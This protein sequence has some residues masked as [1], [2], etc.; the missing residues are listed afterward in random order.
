M[1]VI[2]SFATKP[3]TEGDDQADHW[4]SQMATL[5]LPDVDLNVLRQKLWVEHKIEAPLHRF[6][7]HN[8]IRISIQG[9]NT[10]ADAD[11]LVAGLKA[12]LGR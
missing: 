5:P 8:V 7:E 3:M 1:S 9:Y 4:Y 11:A 10:E 6:G 2:R 12:G